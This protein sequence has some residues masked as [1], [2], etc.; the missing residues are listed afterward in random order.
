MQPKAKFIYLRPGGLSGSI[1]VIMAHT[2]VHRLLDWAK[3]DSL[4]LQS[5]SLKAAGNSIRAM[6]P[7]EK[8]YLQGLVDQFAGEFYSVVAKARPK[9]TPEQWKEIKTAR[10]YIGEDVVKAGLVDG[11]KDKDEVLTELKRLSGSSNIMTR[12]ELKKVAKA[13]QKLDQSPGS[14][15]SSA[16]E[17]LPS[18][19]DK[20]FKEL[21]QLQK[22]GSIQFLYL[23][24]IRL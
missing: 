24:P 23:A 19:V 16:N 3:I 15:G 6:T 9:I 4:I 22:G 14:W 21:E 12:D 1:G 10:I 11:V 17:P 7:E 18:T 5:G 8:T 2:G 20:L 13:A